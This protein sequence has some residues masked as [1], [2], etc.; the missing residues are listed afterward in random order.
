MFLFEFVLI[1]RIAV[2]STL[3]KVAL[4]HDNRNIRVF[5]VS[6]ERIMRLPRSSRQVRAVPPSLS[7]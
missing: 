3:Q 4:P 7:I 5:D 1:F 2:H 6:G